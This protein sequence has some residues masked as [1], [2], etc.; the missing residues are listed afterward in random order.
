MHLLQSSA[1]APCARE[2]LAPVLLAKIFLELLAYSV[3]D[4]Q[5]RERAR[6]APTRGGARPLRGRGAWPGAAGVWLASCYGCPLRRREKSPQPVY[7]G[8]EL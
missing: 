7:L 1:A 2:P 8:Y 6:S 5:S 4:E 3:L